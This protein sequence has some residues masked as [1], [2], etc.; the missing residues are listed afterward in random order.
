V[1][2]L[3]GLVLVVALGLAGCGGSSTLS[4][5]QL[6]AR[7]TRTC[8]LARRRTNRIATPTLPGEGVRFLS[9]GIAALAPELT[10]LNLLRPPTDMASDYKLALAASEG[11][12]RA[13]RSALGGLKA[14]NDPVVAIKTLQQELSPLES[15]AHVAWSSLD[16]PACASS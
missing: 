11:E 5:A 12:L 15:R 13:L 8:N 10:A 1:R 2:R 9:R 3:A 6:H 7:A 4:T 14:G 16:L